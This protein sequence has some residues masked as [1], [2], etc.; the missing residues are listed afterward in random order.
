MTKQTI[1]SHFNHLHN[2]APAPFNPSYKAYASKAQTIACKQLE[3][4]GWYDSTTLAERQATTV[5]SDR[6]KLICNEFETGIRSL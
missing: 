3:L 6:Y 5:I 2:N 1:E 4:E